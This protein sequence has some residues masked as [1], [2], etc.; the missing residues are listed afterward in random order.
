MAFIIDIT[1]VGLAII[2]LWR[3]QKRLAAA[4][5]TFLMT[6]R[7]RDDL[8]L[9]L[10]PQEKNVGMGMVSSSGFSNQMRHL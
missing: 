7:A 10:F 1:V 6:L 2:G 5:K 9:I 3:T 8:Q 4:P